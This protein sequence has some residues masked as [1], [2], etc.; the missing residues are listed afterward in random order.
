MPVCTV[1][2][3]DEPLYEHGEVP[4]CDP[5]DADTHVCDVLLNWYASS[6][7]VT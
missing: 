7:L 2:G 1:I 3:F 4:L 6:W 5:P